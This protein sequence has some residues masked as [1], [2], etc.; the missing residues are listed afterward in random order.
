MAAASMAAQSS[1][2]GWYGPSPLSLAHCSLA[3]SVSGA[4]VA[5]AQPAQLAALDDYGRQIGPPLDLN[6]YYA[7]IWGNNA[8]W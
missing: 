2:A 6:V 3:V 8:G 4:V 5:G 7:W 1:V